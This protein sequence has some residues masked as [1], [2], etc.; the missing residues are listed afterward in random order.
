MISA[1]VAEPL[2]AGRPWLNATNEQLQRNVV[3]QGKRSEKG[4]RDRKRSARKPRG[5]M[6]EVEM[7]SL[8]RRGAS[9][10]VSKGEA[11]SSPSR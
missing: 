2:E 11:V 7:N 8:R 3:R 10:G 9:M 4:R 6:C 5:S 1:S